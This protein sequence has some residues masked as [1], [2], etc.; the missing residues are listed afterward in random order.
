MNVHI[1][2]TTYLYI[3]GTLSFYHVCCST[4]QLFFS[5]KNI[6]YLIPGY[7]NLTINLSHDF[8]FENKRTTGTMQKEILSHLL[9]QP[10]L[11]GAIF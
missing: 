8:F 6:F 11:C 9:K 2:H 10:V 3:P 1:L 4:F 5:K 7:P